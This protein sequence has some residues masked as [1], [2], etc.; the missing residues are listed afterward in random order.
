MM[1]EIERPSLPIEENLT[2]LMKDFTSNEG[3]PFEGL[4]RATHTPPEKISYFLREVPIIGENSC[5][6]IALFPPEISLEETR[7]E[8]NL[9]LNP[10]VISFGKEGRHTI[11]AIYE[12]K[13]SFGQPIY[14]LSSLT[15]VILVAEAGQIYIVSRN[16]PWVALAKKGPVFS[17]AISF[18][19]IVIEKRRFSRKKE[20]IFRGVS[21]ASFFPTFADRIWGHLKSKPGFIEIFH[22]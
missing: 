9:S 22:R 16:Y 5:F 8:C 13:G 11:G 12:E 4:R 10:P 19:E 1:K 7:F 15:E 14:R 21:I 2:P 3:L 18:S 20:E 17:I 6:F